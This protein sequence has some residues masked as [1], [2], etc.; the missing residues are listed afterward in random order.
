[1]KEKFDK[2]EVLNYLTDVFY[3]KAKEFVEEKTDSKLIHLAWS[4][5]YENA[6]TKIIKF[7]YLFKF[8]NPLNM[9]KLQNVCFLLNSKN[10]KLAKNSNIVYKEVED[11]FDVFF[12][13][14]NK[15]ETLELKE[16]QEVKIETSVENLKKEINKII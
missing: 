4:K 11:G 1:M 12:E 8:G 10:L 14:C 6:E 13:K 15:V 3:A 7:K 2:K 16:E 5:I 9:N